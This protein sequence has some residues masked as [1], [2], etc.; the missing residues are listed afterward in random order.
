M[1]IVHNSHIPHDI[2]LYR[3]FEFDQRGQLII[4]A[5]IFSPEETGPLFQMEIQL[6][7][8]PLAE[9]LTTVD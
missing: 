2:F 7:S 4:Q 9:N 3:M 8:A 5:H 6:A 1:D